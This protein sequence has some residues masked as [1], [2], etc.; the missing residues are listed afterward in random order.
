METR[1]YLGSAELANVF[2]WSQVWLHADLPRLSPGDTQ[3]H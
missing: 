1:R 3:H 2:E